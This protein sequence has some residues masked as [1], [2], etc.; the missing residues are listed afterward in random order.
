MSA[1]S[2]GADR[3]PPQAVEVE[4]AVLGA[5]LLDQDAISQVIDIIDDTDFYRDAHRKIFQAI[6]SLFE[7][8]EPTDLITLTTELSNRKQLNDVGGA[9]YLAGLAD[10]VSTA[11]NAEY[12]ANIVHEKAMS[13]KLITSSNQIIARAFDQSE[14]PDDLLDEAEQM[15]FALSEQRLKRGFTHLNPILHDTFENIE[16]LHERSTGVTGVATGFNKLDELTAGFQPGELI[17]VAARPAMGKTALCLN[18]A[19]HASVDGKVGVGIFS[20]EMANH[21]LAQRMLCSEAR[22][23]S[24]L[25]RTGR[26]PGDAWSNLSIA[27]GSL[28]KA[29]I[30]ID[31]TPALSVLEMRSR[32][33]RLMSEHKDLGLLV[34]DYLQLMRGPKGIESRQQEI[35]IISRSLKALAKE[36]NVP[37]IALSQLSR[38]VESRGDGRP[39]LSDLRES[40]A[41]EQDA[42]VVLFIYRPVRYGKVE[43]AELNKAEII[44]GKQR[45]GPVGSIELVFL[46]QYAT[47]EN[48]DF[49][50]EPLDE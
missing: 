26:L 24:H 12:H 15:I 23:D 39:Q 7:R 50:H 8:N 1:D 34:V 9:F 21:Q 16:R 20:L 48:P 46:D 14:N 41:I 43:E 47:F 49:Y 35:S 30:Y 10:N 29:P 6:I 38:A 22:V 2:N 40:G 45:N 32:A 11:A 25:M 37:I 28:A 5:L 18:I 33:R 27:V 4:A 19:R 42:D 17:I 13:R 44:I 3:V 36:L 31:E